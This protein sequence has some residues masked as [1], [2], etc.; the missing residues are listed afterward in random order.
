MKYF[1]LYDATGN[2]IQK[3]ISPAII[4]DYHYY[5]TRSNTNKSYYDLKSTRMLKIKFNHLNDPKKYH[6]KIFSI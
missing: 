5:S 3:N 1:I 6:T 2:P 4:K